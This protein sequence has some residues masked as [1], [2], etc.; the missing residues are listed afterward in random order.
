MQQNP[1]LAAAL[2]AVLIPPGTA[3]A[4]DPDVLREIVITATPI[5]EGLATTSQ[6]VGVLAGDELLLKLEPTLGETVAGE[7]GVH[8]TYFG[9]GS[10]RP[11]IRGLGGDRVQVLTDGLPTLDVSGLSEDHAIAIDPALSEQVEI[12]RGPATLLYGTGASGGIV[13]VVTNRLHDRLP[14]TATGMLELRADTAHDERGM[15]GRLDAPLGA[16]ALHVDGAWRETDDYDIPGSAGG[17]R[18][19]VPNSWTDTRSGGVGATRIGEQWLVGAAASHHATEYGIPGGDEAIS[20]D[21]QQERYD[22]LLGRRSD[23]LDWRLEAGTT[24]YRHAELEPEGDIGTLYDLD[25]S[26]VRLAFQHQGPFGLQGSSGLQWQQLDL[27]ARGEE[28]FV[29]NSRTRTLGA[30]LF[31]ERSFSHWSLEVGARLDRTEVDGEGLKGFAGEALN[32]SMGVLVPLGSGSTLIGQLASIERHPSAT[33]LYADGPHAATGQ[34]EIGNDGFDSERGI[35]LELGWRLLEGSTTLELRAFYTDYDR[36]LFLAPTG[37]VEDE[38]PVFE[39][40]QQGASFHGLEARLD[41][42]PGGGPWSLGVFGDLVRAR[43]DDGSN[44]PRIPPLRLGGELSYQRERLTA[45]ISARHHLE[46]DHTA[47][48]ETRT[49]GFTLLEAELAWR[50]ARL[51]GDTLLFLRGSNLLDE[52]ARVH[53]SPLKDRVPLPGRSITAGVRLSFGR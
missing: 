14:E 24:R 21:L 52:V 2:A 5:A 15:A 23:A 22:F 31:Q 53:S 38:L 9:P 28:A 18:G 37:E 6:A 34:Y 36:Y 47:P 50:P 42:Q 10:S 12:I 4:E 11:V 29:P 7:P 19:R 17:V 16:W 35:H 40:R 41:W 33:E 27:L 13:N 3:L 51:P 39:F 20:I 49:A 30:F 8:S 43:L 32:L 48:G 26:E 1:L 45:G 25:G 44:L 46:Q